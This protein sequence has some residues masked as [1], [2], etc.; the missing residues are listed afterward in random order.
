[1]LY[2]V[3][4]NTETNETEIY[5]ANNHQEFMEIDKLED[6][7]QGRNK[8][9]GPWRVKPG[10]LSVIPQFTLS[11]SNFKQVS[12]TF[13]DI[14]SKRKDLGGKK[15]VIV[16]TP[17]IT[18]FPFTNNIDY[19]MLACDGVF[20]VLT[21]EEVNEIIWETVDF[22]KNNKKHQDSKSSDLFGM[23]LNDCVNNVLKRSLIQNSEDNVTIILVA[24]RNFLD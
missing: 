5:Y 21:N 3:S 7:N 17:E 22:Y 4:S 24:F 18:T 15:G 23:C 11:N 12:R 6:M 10:G 8:I 20:D 14:E 13:G 16:P 1:M 9:F 19:V 2:R